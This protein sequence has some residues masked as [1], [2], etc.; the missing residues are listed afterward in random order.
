MP[1]TSHNTRRTVTS[2]KISVSSSSTR[3]YMQALPLTTLKLCLDHNHLPHS[4]RNA[5]IVELP[6]TWQAIS[7]PLP[8]YRRV[9]VVDKVKSVVRP[10]HRHSRPS[11]LEPSLTCSNSVTTALVQ[12]LIESRGR[13]S[14]PHHPLAMRYT[15]TGGRVHVRTSKEGHTLSLQYNTE[16]FT[17]LYCY[18][19]YWP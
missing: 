4:G 13:P 16:I 3:E 2:L 15:H 10:S 7:L 5:T 19:R 9:A 18:L 1:R 11:S 12:T 8:V 14:S 6:H 17:N